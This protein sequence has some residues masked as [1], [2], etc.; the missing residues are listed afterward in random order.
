MIVVPHK[1]RIVLLGMMT[2]MPVAGVVWQNV[3]YL[4]GFERLGYEVYYV[5]AHGR[6]PTSFM[7]TPTCDGAA[8]AAAFIDRVCRQYDL[9]DRWCLQDRDA[10]R[11]FGLSDVQLRDLYQSAHLIIN[12]HGGHVPADLSGDRSGRTAD[13]A[14]PQQERSD[15]L[16]RPA[17]RVLHLRRKPRPPRL[18]APDAD[19]IR[20]QTHTTT[21]RLRP[22]AEKRR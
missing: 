8:K 3:H 6:T 2:K 5:E 4:L 17:P 20:V 15:R 11:N 14:P 18:Q 10:G 21:R 9:G 16:P 12:L 22:L 1:K 13:R 19:A 7:E